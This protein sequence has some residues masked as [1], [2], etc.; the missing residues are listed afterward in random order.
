MVIPIPGSEFDL[1]SFF[2]FVIKATDLIARLLFLLNGRKR[3]GGRKWVVC[4]NETTQNI[5]PEQKGFSS[6]K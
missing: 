5:P 4:P 6:K 1:T 2:Y 3:T